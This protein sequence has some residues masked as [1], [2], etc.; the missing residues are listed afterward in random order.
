MTR[1]TIGYALAVVAA[2]ALAAG[3]AW[4]HDL[5]AAYEGYR[6]S[7]NEVSVLETRKEQVE[8]QEAELRR[9]VKELHED[10][11]ELEAAIRADQGHVR[12]GETV[13]H[14][15]WPPADESKATTEAH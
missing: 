11:L 2:F 13:Y 4:R 3:I 1:S 14:V 15:E 12:D 5:R 9:Q 7:G 8:I 6:F 10:S